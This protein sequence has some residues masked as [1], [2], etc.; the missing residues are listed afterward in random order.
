MDR[1]TIY[2]TALAPLTTSILARHT[3]RPFFLTMIRALKMKANKARW[4]DNV[5]SRT[6]ENKPGVD[7]IWEVE[8]DMRARYPQ[9][10]VTAS[11][12]GTEFSSRLQFFFVFTRHLQEESKDPIKLDSE[13]ER[14]RRDGREGDRAPPGR[15]RRKRKK[16]ERPRTAATTI[17][18]AGDP[19][20]AAATRRR[21]TYGKLSVSPLCGSSS[22]NLFPVMADSD[23]SCATG[24]SLG[25]EGLGIRECAVPFPGEIGS[26]PP[27]IT[28]ADHRTTAVDRRPPV[29]TTI[30]THGTST[31][32]SARTGVMA[33][34]GYGQINHHEGSRG[35]AVEIPH[36]L[37]ILSE[38]V[39][40]PHYCT[41]GWPGS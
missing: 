28:A 6:F 1:L 19:R 40:M 37:K 5:T 41:L 18:A 31:L 32:R 33:A 35:V 7:M 20:T 39:V 9:L 26:S 8:D 30:P 38:V 24:D 22:C 16:R 2:L 29:T 14:E 10:F 21:R 36:S 27:A 17:A 11:N 25:S 34:C 15:S 12:S 23:L 4:G 13:T 3:P